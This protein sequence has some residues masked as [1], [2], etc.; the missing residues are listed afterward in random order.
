MSCD[1][2]RHTQF[3]RFDGFGRAIDLAKLAKELGYTAL[4]VSDHGNTSGLV[5]MYDACKREGI[6]PI[7]GVEGYFLP[8][9]KPQQRG[10]HLCLFAKDLVGYRN[11]NAIQFDGEKQKYYNPI[12]TFELLEKYREGLICT[13]A[14]IASYSS[15]C[16]LKGKVDQAKKYLEKL[17]SIFG[18]DL[19]VEVQPYKVSEAGAQEKINVG[20]I[21]LADELGLKCVLTSDSHR[22]RKE[23]F[24][25][26]LKM[27]LMDGHDPEWVRG[28]YEERY[29]PAMW[30]MEKRFVKM[31]GKDFNNAKA[32]AK[33]MHNNLEE[34]EAK[35]DGDIL[36]KLPLQLPKV[37]SGKDS[38][39][40]IVR[41]I[42]EGLKK[43]G[44]YT[45][46]YIQ[47]CK[48][49]LDVIKTNGF[50]DYFLI[51]ADYVNWAKNRGICVGPGRGSVCNS[52]VA[53]AMHI[54]DVDSIR[55]NLDFRR[56]MRYDKKAFPDI[57][58]DFEMDRRG[59]VIEYLI[60]K[61]PGQSARVSSYGLYQ[62][63]NTINDLAKVC[64][65]P[66]DKTVDE[67]EAKAHKETI[68]EMKKVINKYKTEDGSI[69]NDSLLH[70]E[71]ES[72]VSMWNKKYDNIIIHFTKLFGKVRFIGTHAAGVILTS[73]DVLQYTSIRMDKAGNL[74]STFNLED[75]NSINIIK[76]DLLGL[77][78]MQ[79]I[80]ECR[81][82]AGKTEFDIS[83]V[84]DPKLLDAFRE[85]NTCG[86]FQFEK[87][88]AKRILSEINCDCFDDVVATCAMNRPGPL[89]MG[90][91]EQYADNKANQD[92]I[93]KQDLR[94]QYTKESYGSVVYQEQ[95]LLI[96]VYIGG[97]EW[98]EADRV[99]KANKHG[100]KEKAVAILN[101][102]AQDSGVDLHKKFVKNAMKK[103]MTRETAE[104]TWDSLLVYSF[105]KGHAAGYCIIS[106]E[107]MFYKIYYPTYF[108]Y[109]K[110]KYARTDQERDEFC[111]EAVAAD[112]LVFLPHVN[113]SGVGTSIRKVDGELV[114]QKGLAEIKGIG[115]KAAQFIMDERKKRGIFRD[116]DEFYDRCA[117]RVVNKKVLNILFEQGAIEF[118]KKQYIKRVT[119]YNT[120]LYSRAQRR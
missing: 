53:Y 78:T 31:H 33:Q 51:V 118:N 91:P 72:L 62:V 75:L 69:D 90:M 110:I 82:L 87:D 105:N 35:V 111:N 44:Q 65:L 63:D 106:M 109:A 71:D 16:I 79:S 30:E 1:L 13:T 2:H 12:W 40:E 6:K 107:E 9:Y 116:Y 80:G 8:V 43:R 32:L 18:E 17:Q 55:F 38:E 99:L 120:A 98:N 22:G 112:N 61:Y 52:L 45:K 97:L 85:G 3:S 100:F 60:D 77:K 89:S 95:L 37:D 36:G 59:E 76:F 88:T 7:L 115:E 57:D 23:D 67:Q 20:M 49:E 11:L 103:G 96:C 108:W 46:E 86:I 66:T 48:E 25:T 15:Q 94:Y 47:R 70:G 114:L 84:D 5:Q 28:T 42:K 24:D 73:G 34:L 92:Q 68:R 83:E 50:I 4:G 58:M 39:K 26:Y 10:F 93:D 19:Y 104:G 113:Y 41:Q 54:T 74:Y 64:G 101:K 27:H 119:A 14:C 29:M 81:K 102:Y 21:R 56:F 117:G